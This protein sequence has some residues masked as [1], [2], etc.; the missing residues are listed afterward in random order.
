MSHDRAQLLGLLQ[1]RRVWSGGELA[2]RLQVTTRSVRRDVERLR[3]L[4]YPVHASTGLGGGY[5]L[6]SRRWRCD[7]ETGHGSMDMRKA[8]QNGKARF[9][10]LARQ[11][12]QD[13]SASSGGDLG[14]AAPGQF[15]PEFE[16]PM[17][18]LALN[19]VSEP[20]VSRFGVHLI[21]V[22][23]RR[24][25][26]LSPAEQRELVRNLLRERKTKETYDQWV[27]DLRARAY[28]ELR[29]PPQ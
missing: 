3:E 4:G 12:S 28:V 11:Y 16:Q 13:G 14:W 20:V 2:E 15:V 23:E 18:A 5:Q 25:A 17:N 6:G 26:E 21:Q 1:S 22:L 8:I 7:K 19:Q 24:E 29:E 9:E 10:D 27:R